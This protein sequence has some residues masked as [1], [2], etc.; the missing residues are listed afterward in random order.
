M[1]N[2]LHFGGNPMCTAISL[3]QGDHYFGRNLDMVK[4]YDEQIV[5]TPRNYPFRFRNG[6]DLLHHHAMIGMATVA[7]HYPLYYEATNERGLSMAALN[8]PDQAMYFP[9]TVCKDN[10]APFELIPWV[11]SQCAT[12]Q[13]AKK[14]LLRLNIWML[15]FS[16]EYM[17]TPMHW[18]I[19]DKTGSFVLE[20]T[21]EGV[22]IY[23]D[24]VGVLTNGPA[25]PYHLSNLANY[26]YLHSTDQPSNFC[27]IPYSGYSGGMGA[28]GLPGDY[29]T[30]SRFI[31][32]AYLRCTSCCASNE[33]GRVAQFF[34]LLNA[35]AM[36]KGA[37]ILEDGPEITLYSCCCNADKGIYYYTTYENSR[38]S[39]VNLHHA[40][41]T[42]SILTHFPLRT[43]SEIFV[44]N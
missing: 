22:R 43:F 11:L 12:V 36:P 40:D 14:L 41:L 15:P 38:I 7:N 33:Q 19:A 9:R 25:F 16:R 29:S 28:M 39:A 24:P 35:V 21:E 23:D 1:A 30:A 5:I 17:L 32:A 6:L 37:V 4:G 42:G 10:I 44:Q 26:R 2:Q 3:L 31:K 13:E 27:G 34:H 8:F 20:S 18:L